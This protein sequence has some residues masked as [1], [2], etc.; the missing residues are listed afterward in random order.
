MFNRSSPGRSAD[1]VNR[2]LRDGPAYEMGER[3]KWRGR[4]RQRHARRTDTLEPLVPGFPANPNHDYGLK[5]R[6]QIGVFFLL[7]A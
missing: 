3:K 5:S 2:N 1:T 4:E 6:T 7:A